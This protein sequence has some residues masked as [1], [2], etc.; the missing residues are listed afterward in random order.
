VIDA[1]ASP[2]QAPA[3]QPAKASRVWRMVLIVVSVQLV[4]IAAG[5]IL[6]TAMGLANDGVGSCGGG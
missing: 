4:L 3:E 1:I 5:M 2:P 6:F